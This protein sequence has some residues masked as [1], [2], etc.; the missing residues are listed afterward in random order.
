MYVLRCAFGGAH[1][2]FALCGSE[3]GSIALWNREN[4]AN[5]LVK[6]QG[7]AQVVNCVQWCPTDALLFAS[8]SDDMTVRLWGVESVS[9]CEVI[10]DS[11]ELKRVDIVKQ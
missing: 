6:L 1:D 9:T 5:P 3:D 8:A 11:R 7:H 4:P 10:E 2:G